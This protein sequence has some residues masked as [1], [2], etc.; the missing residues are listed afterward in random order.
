MLEHQRQPHNMGL[1]SKIGVATATIPMYETDQNPIITAIFYAIWSSTDMMG[2]IINTLFSDMTHTITR[3]M[4]YAENTYTLGLPHGSHG[5]VYAVS[6]DVVAAIVETDLG[7]PVGSVYVQYN[8]AEI[9][10]AET[11]FLPLLMRLYNYDPTHSIL[12]S[13]PAA[14][15]TTYPNAT[16]FITYLTDITLTAG[17][18][19]ATLTYST[20][21]DVSREVFDGS[22]ETWSTEITKTKIGDVQEV[23][24]VPGGLVVGQLY[25]R[26]V[27]QR[28]NADGSLID[29]VQIWYY[30]VQTDVYPVLTP[31]KIISVSDQFLPVIPIRYANVD[32]TDA[33]HQSTALYQTSK[34]LLQRINIRIQDIADALNSN[35]NIADVDHAYIT[36][37]INVR[38]AFDCEPAQYYLAQFFDRLYSTA[39]MTKFDFESALAVPNVDG[40]GAIG[41]NIYSF[42]E[43]VITAVPPEDI[44]VS[45]PEGV[46]QVHNREVRTMTTQGLDQQILFN[47]ITSETEV[48]YIGPVGSTSMRISP[49][50]DLLHGYGGT[51]SGDAAPVGTPVAVQKINNSLLILKIQISSTTVKVITVCGL[52][53]QNLV[54]HEHAV[55]TSLND[56]VNAPVGEENNNLFIPI[57]YEISDAMRPSQRMVLYPYS[58]HLIINAYDRI[59]LEWYE[60]SL[61]A[62]IM[63]VVALILAVWTGHGWLVK[64]ATSVAAVAAGTAGAIVALLIFLLKTIVVQLIFNY[65]F[66]LAVEEWGA[67]LGIILG[68]VLMVVGAATGQFNDAT[69]LISVTAQMCLQIGLAA[70]TQGNIGLE[71]EAREIR[72]DTTEFNEYASERMD[73]LIDIEEDLLGMDAAYDPLLFTKVKNNVN[74]LNESPSD[75]YDRTIHI[76]NIGTVVLGIPAHFHDKALQLPRTNMIN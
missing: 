54:Y 38:T 17:G 16:N 29:G 47:Y 48:G 42:N 27:Y 52:V 72:E 56:L 20:Y 10:D 23:L 39:V 55:T 50:E 21:A 26:A 57:L 66:K 44:V 32:M 75:F 59:H 35:P 3:M 6:N 60:T 7:Y 73:Q 28:I 36:F 30:D 25:H 67:K 74:L 4:R 33:A 62:F 1:K 51:A 53:H 71:N 43:N 9:L 22:T 64:L 69:S 46:G 19:S 63:I 34:Q 45:Y 24:A 8:V 12:H 31:Q 70:W 11:A 14:S 40:S 49:Q 68:V 37:G 61:F 76:G 13:P 58:V 18:A 5:T 2:H 65:I 15:P 41:V